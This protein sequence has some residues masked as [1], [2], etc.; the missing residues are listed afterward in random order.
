[1]NTFDLKDACRTLYPNG[2]FFTFRRGSSK[3][4]I[5]KINFSSELHIESYQQSDPCLS[6]H[7]LISA[8]FHFTPN[9]NLGPG[10]WRNNIKYYS[11][12]EF[13][14]RFNYFWE[15]Y[16]NSYERNNNLQKWWQSF[17]YFF[18]IKSIRYAKE[19][20]QKEKRESQMREQGLNNLTSL[21]NCNPFSQSLLNHYS[22]LKK[23]IIDDRIKSIKEKL[24]K[25]DAR[26]LMRGDQ[27]TKAFF[28]KF[29]NKRKQNY[30][31]ALK[32]QS[33]DRVTDISGI[34]RIAE[35]YA[36]NLYSGRH[37]SLDQSMMDFFLDYVTPNDECIELF[38]ELMA[39]ISEGEL[40]DAIKSFLN[41]KTPGPDGLSIEFYKIMFP[42]IKDELLKLFNFYMSNGRISSKIKSGLQVWIPKDPPLDEK[43]NYR[44]I[45]L[46][47]C[48]YKI[49]NKIISNRLQ[50]ILK[51]LIHDTQFAQPG[52]DINE[53]N[54]LVRDIID[55]M[56]ASMNDSFFLSI[57][58]TKAFDTIC[59][60]FLFQILAKYGF[61]SQFISLVKELFRDAGSHILINKFRSKKVK[62]KSGTQ[63]GNTISRDLFILQLNLLL[64]N[65]YRTLL[66]LK[67]IACLSRSWW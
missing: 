49:F 39:P 26:Y 59:H 14:Q 41:G 61:P 62:L 53:M 31:K 15:I 20:A 32:N 40:W 24:F 48:D 58:F 43:E 8:F 33:G 23:Q 67:A 30:I 11:D 3:S 52:K 64:K 5:D 1:M 7:D 56:K 12:E 50:P 60:E 21:L 35:E 38:R 19:I 28:D 16:K 44:P 27:P 46:M 9:Q 34:L 6:D 66:S 42:V 47:N 22:V 57:D 54:C 29:K 13:L 37:S 63:Q 55:D 2:S 51:I 4:R 25:E 36:N 10:V 65:I 45:T 17:K 18:K